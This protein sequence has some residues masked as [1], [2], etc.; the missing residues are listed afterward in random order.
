MLA[1][2]KH[3]CNKQNTKTLTLETPTHWLNRRIPFQNVGSSDARRTEP[4][5]P[6]QPEKDTLDSSDGCGSLFES[7]SSQRCRRV[8]EDRSPKTRA[9]ARR[10]R[11]NTSMTPQRQRQGSTQSCQKRRENQEPNKTETL[12]AKL[13]SLTSATLTT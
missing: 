1:K 2:S 13:F 8:D 10:N 3:R 12:Q 6:F 5:N 4:R 9:M 7:K 11:S